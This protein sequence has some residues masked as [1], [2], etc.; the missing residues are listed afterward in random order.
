MINGKCVGFEKGT[1]KD[2]ETKVDKTYCRAYFITSDISDAAGCG[3]KTE[4]VTAYGDDSEFFFDFLFKNKCI[5]KTLIVDTFGYGNA[6]ARSHFIK[7][8]K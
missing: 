3:V 4:S 6:L 1:Y 2:K 8:D 7:I 5:D